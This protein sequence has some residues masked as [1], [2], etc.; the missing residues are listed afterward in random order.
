MSK[1]LTYGGSTAARTIACPQWVELAKKMPPK[2]SGKA[3]D[4]GNLLHDA[5]EAVY[6]DN[7]TFDELVGVLEYNGNVLTA[8]QV[9]EQLKPALR[10]MEALLDKYKIESEPIVEP[11]VELEKDHIGGSID[12]IAASGRTVVLAD[13]KFGNGFVSAH[14]N[15]QLYFYAMCAMADSKTAHL[16]K[17]CECL[18]FA[19]IQPAVAEEPMVYET[20]PTAV[21]EFEQRYLQAIQN[22]QK[23]QS[24]GHCQYCPAAP[25]CPELKAKAMSA[26]KMNPKTA[27]EISE[28]LKLIE[29]LKPW[30]SQVETQTLELMTEGVVV[31]GFKV[32]A[33]RANKKW[34]DD[35][36]K[37]IAHILGEQ[38]YKKE[39]ISPAQA[40][41]IKD[42]V[43]FVEPLI[44]Q[45]EGKP[46]IA[47]E[48]DKRQAISFAMPERL[49]DLK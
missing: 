19:I 22:T 25:I 2:K 1:H 37:E 16:F 41:K 34:A 4:L 3:A 18:V 49:K 44:V 46:T 6:R 32:V 29:D 47:P 36:E 8:E 33:G 21:A 40:L 13:Y 23:I 7:K 39:L 43:A 10:M 27:E 11:F 31:P 24:G 5:M 20:T 30:I 38:A 12:L 14:E 45:P 26:L 35:A 15:A 28:A 42:K 17:D 48:S 9:E